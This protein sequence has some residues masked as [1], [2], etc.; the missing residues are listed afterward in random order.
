MMKVLLGFLL[1]LILGLQVAL[2]Q[3]L[4]AVLASFKAANQLTSYRYKLTSTQSTSDTTLNKEIL[5]QFKPEI[6]EIRVSKHG[7]LV[8]GTQ[9]MVWYG[10]EKMIVVDEHSK[11]VVVY[12]NPK[13]KKKNKKRADD[14]KR[15]ETSVS[16]LPFIDSL[17]VHLSAVQVQKISE[18]VYQ[19]HYT[20]QQEVPVEITL[21]HRLGDVFFY[22]MIFSS[23]TAG[24]SHNLVREISDFSTVVDE[25]LMSEDYYF[26]AQQ[27][28]YIVSNNFPQYQLLFLDYEN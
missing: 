24:V 28:T 5:A 19:Y 18:E 25:K 8:I 13:E 4:S 17:L 16:Y 14:K 21:F 10:A 11:T 1:A 26:V 2:G 6:M 27:K 22:K 9:N 23:I 12:Q 20:L 7:T 15:M 3:D